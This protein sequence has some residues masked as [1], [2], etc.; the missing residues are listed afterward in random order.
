[1]KKSAFIVALSAASAVAFPNDIDASNS[2]S[3]MLAKAY[4]LSKVLESRP[5]HEETDLGI[6]RDIYKEISESEESDS[7]GKCTHTSFTKC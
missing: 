6:L 1:M 2:Q 5:I 3:R 4:Q 7:Y